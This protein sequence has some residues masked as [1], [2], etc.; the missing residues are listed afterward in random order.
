MGDPKDGGGSCSLSADGRLV[1][2]TSEATNL[3][4]G[5]TNNEADIFVRTRR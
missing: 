2:F 1:V 5:D 3:V 4:P